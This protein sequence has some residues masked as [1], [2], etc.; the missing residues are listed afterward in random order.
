MELSSAHSTGLTLH[1]RMRE[2]DIDMR[3]TRNDELYVMS[4]CNILISVAS[5]EAA[6]ISACDDEDDSDVSNA[7]RSF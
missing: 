1:A 5:A 6:D 7:F 3:M 2:Y 4:A